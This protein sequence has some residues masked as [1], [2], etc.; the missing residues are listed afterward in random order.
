MAFKELLQEY[1]LRRDLLMLFMMRCFGRASQ[2]CN[3]EYRAFTGRVMYPQVIQVSTQATS[4]VRSNYEMVATR[5]T[6]NSFSI[7]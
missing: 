6:I 5:Q 4:V 7:S 1:P 3:K 2:C